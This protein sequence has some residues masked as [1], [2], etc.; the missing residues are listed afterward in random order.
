[1]P[2]DEKYAIS[3]RT[4][5][6]IAGA[7]TAGYAILKGIP[8]IQAA[9]QTVQEASEAPLPPTGVKWVPTVCLMCEAAC[10][11]RVKVVKGNAIKVEGNPAFPTNQGGLCPKG[12]AA[13]QVLYDP[14]RIRTPLRRVGERGEGKFEAISWPQALDIAVQKLK[15]LRDQ[16]QAHTVAFMGAR[17]RGHM[18]ELVFRFLESYG[19]PNDIVLSGVGSDTAQK[20]YL[21]AQGS[22]EPLAYDLVNANYVMFFG[23]AWAESLVPIVEITRLMGQLR[24]G[25]PGI[26]AKIVQV[27][28]RYSVSAAK[29]DEQVY[30]RPGTYGALALGMANVIIRERLYDD[31]FVSSRC[32]GFEDW[33]DQSGKKH[34]GFKTIVLRDYFPVAVARITGLE[35][36]TIIR[37]AREFARYQPCLA[38]GGGGAGEHTNGVYSEWAIHCLN[39]LMGS[40]GRPGGI[41]DRHAASFAPWPEVKIDQTAKDG[42]SQPRLDKAGTAQYPLA[43]GVGRAFTE[44]LQSGSPYRVNALFLYY[45]NPAYSQLD[46]EA[47]T[48]ALAQVPFIASFSPFKDDTTLYADLVLPDHTFMERLDDDTVAPTLGYPMVG[49]RQP[50]VEPLYDTANAGDVI[51]TMAH[52]VGGSVGNAFPWKSYRRA[53]QDALSG[54]SQ[55]GRGEPQGGSFTAFWQKVLDQGGWWD[56]KEMSTGT[57]TFKTPSKKFEFYSQTLQQKL[58]ALAKKEAGSISED[59]ALDNLFKGLRIMARGDDPYLAH[60][61][62]PRIAGDEKEYPL[63]LNTY[64]PMMLAEGQGV[65]T[66]WLLEN[67]GSHVTNN[68]SSW[69][70]ISPETAQALHVRDRDVVWVE[71]PRGKFKTSVKV[72]AGTLPE[73]VNMPVG[74]GHKGSG[75]SD[76][77]SGPNP[78]SAMVSDLDY[79]AG[80]PARGGTRVKIYR[81]DG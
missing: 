81:A 60:Y 23:A 38:L 50:A 27:D 80:T 16:G 33:Q 4:F 20:A 54:I 11:M 64:K 22:E 35:E 12:Q 3:R 77:D 62:A 39:A 68:W 66:P 29:A 44:S 8:G 69:I 1:M 73:V 30:V 31:R 65:N 34:T 37:L 13:L 41:L 76:V 67:Y 46:S 53:I 49:I 74:F 43:G 9:T 58:Q 15:S 63:F 78:N 17:Y 70:E 40:F 48:R 32:F 45:A 56:T 5:L 71:S 7:T 21:L 51:I 2:D 24:Q 26:R 6:K 61:E 42:L 57:F 36:G 14:D 59:V 19:T 10:G 52:M 47:F 55:K 75:P 18:R 28:V 72:F 25:R 79:L